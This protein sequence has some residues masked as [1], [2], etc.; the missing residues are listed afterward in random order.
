MSPDINQPDDAVSEQREPVVQMSAG[1][2]LREHL[3][4]LHGELR[5][6]D[7]R[8]HRFEPDSIHQMRIATRQLRSALTT[9][10]SLLVRE[11]S[12]PVRT[13]LGW[14][15]DVL[16]LARDAEVERQRLAELAANESADLVMGPVAERLDAHFAVIYRIAHHHVL[17]ALNSERY[18]KLVEALDILVDD[19]PLR[20]AAA[21]PADEVMPELVRRDW[22]RLSRAFAAAEHAL[23]GPRRDLFLHETRKAAKRARYSAEAVIP[24]VGRRAEKFARA[25]KKLQTLLGEHHDSVQLRTVLCEVATEAHL[26]G[27]DSFTYGRLHAIE[28][29][30]AEWIEAQLPAAWDRVDARHRWM[31]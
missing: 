4:K 14:L 2:V 26:D 18:L 20:S 1:D 8:V 11:S 13:E 21:E 22:K 24:V 31:R 25:A 16:G 19:L 5:T 10:R 7:G 6:C 15:A 17:E 9:F 12:E 30:R 28:Q 23:P 29:A 3:S 27:Q